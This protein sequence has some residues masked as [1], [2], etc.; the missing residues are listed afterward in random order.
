MSTWFYRDAE[1]RQIG[2]VAPSAMLD[3]IRGGQ[4][5]EDTLVRKGDSPW[6]RSIEINGLWAAAGR[7]TAEFHCPVC[8][9]SLPKPPCRCPNCQKYID[10]AVGKIAKPAVSAAQQQRISTV[11]AASKVVIEQASRLPSRHAT[12]ENA[13][14]AEPPGRQVSRRPAAAVERRWWQVL[15]RR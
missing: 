9:T 14:T 6:K 4:I 15:F 12:V 13:R 1:D 5:G 10:H 8:N 7:P 3:L 11:A 2:P